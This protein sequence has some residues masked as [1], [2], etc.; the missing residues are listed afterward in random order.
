MG[1]NTGA[2]HKNT[3]SEWSLV[4]A[5]GPGNSDFFVFPDGEHPV[6]RPGLA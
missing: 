2:R 6:L 5:A 3:G 4:A 1:P